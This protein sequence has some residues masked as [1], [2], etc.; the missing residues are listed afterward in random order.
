MS[1]VHHQHV[2]TKSA[3]DTASSESSDQASRTAGAEEVPPS[4]GAARSCRHSKR[5]H[6]EHVHTQR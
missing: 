3:H 2:A 6:D 5:I 1:Y 4:V